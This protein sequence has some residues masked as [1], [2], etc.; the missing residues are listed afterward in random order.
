M[1]D[2]RLGRGVVLEDC[3]VGPGT[4][5]PDRFEARGR[6][7]SRGIWGGPPADRPLGEV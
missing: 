1:E 5:I 3:L 2:C 7:L 4:V 6:L